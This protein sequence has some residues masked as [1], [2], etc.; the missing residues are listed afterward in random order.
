MAI[1]SAPSI[2]PA[3][4]DTHAIFSLLTLRTSVKLPQPA[5]RNFG[6]VALEKE[7][8]AHRQ[9]PEGN[10]VK[11]GCGGAHRPS[12]IEFLEIFR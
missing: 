8:S 1:G 5:R 12:R 9:P 4:A 10:L 6:L 3:V 11:K 2:Q 7:V